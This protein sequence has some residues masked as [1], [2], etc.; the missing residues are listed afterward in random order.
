MDTTMKL[1]AYK[2]DLSFLFL[3]YLSNICSFDDEFSPVHYVTS[4]QI[5]PHWEDMVDEDKKTLSQ[6]QGV[7][8]LNKAVEH[9]V[10]RSLLTELAQNDRTA[11]G[12][13]LVET[14]LSRCTEL[15][16]TAD[17]LY[18]L[19]M[20]AAVYQALGNRVEAVKTLRNGIKIA[21]ADR[22]LEAERQMKEG[23]CRITA[24]IAGPVVCLEM[25]DE[26]LSDLSSYRRHCWNCN[27]TR[28]ENFKKC[29]KCAEMRHLAS[30][31]WQDR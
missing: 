18:W 14:S 25:D 1:I 13:D 20:M 11:E 2:N 3:F 24:E 17:A 6:G 23:L 30:Y 19:N 26:A 27:A 21:Q 4:D 15:H 22:S 5:S 9:F 12:M 7:I 29:S 16:E 10:R 8:T 31:G 28:N